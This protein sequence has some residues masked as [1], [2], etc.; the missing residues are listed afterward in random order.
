[1]EQVFVIDNKTKIKNLNND[2]QNKFGNTITGFAR[3]E[4]GE[5]LDD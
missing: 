1:M 3:F 5:D 4:V 2:I